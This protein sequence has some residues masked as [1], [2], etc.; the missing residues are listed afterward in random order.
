MTV[1][2]KS[3]TIS[4]TSAIQTYPFSLPQLPYTAE[5]MAPVIDAET[6]QLHHSKHHQAYVDKLNDALKDHGELQKLDLLTLIGKVN[7]VPESVRNAVRNQGGGHVNHS[8]FWEIMG[9]PNANAT[10]T[11]P[12]ADLITQNFGSFDDFRK[13]FNTAGEKQFGS[14]WVFVTVEDSGKLAIVAQ[15]NQDTP[16]SQGKKVL[17]GND[18][19]EHAYYLSYR[20]RRGEYLQAWWQVLDWQKV[21]ARY[22]ALKAGEKII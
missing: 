17:F 13:Q 15:P 9:K 20:N 11:G 21:A 18:V 3:L 12:L 4:T 14:G 19:W 22:D 6:M 16:L 1:P 10:P 7:E 5:T 2:A 8:M